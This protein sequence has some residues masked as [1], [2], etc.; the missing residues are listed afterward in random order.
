MKNTGA[1]Y[2]KA[3]DDYRLKAST[4]NVQRVG[5][6]LAVICRG[7]LSRVMRILIHIVVG[8]RGSA[9]FSTVVK[10]CEI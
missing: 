6:F 5:T 10:Y 1:D 7:V 9:A 2:V 4:S 3:E 8:G